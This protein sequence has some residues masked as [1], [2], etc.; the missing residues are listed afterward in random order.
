MVHEVK[1]MD[2]SAD[3]LVNECSRCRC[4]LEDLREEHLAGFSSSSGRPSDGTSGR[5]ASH[6]QNLEH[7]WLERRRRKKVFGMGLLLR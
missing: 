4:S 6:L 5:A 1:L 7:R 3:K 2:Y